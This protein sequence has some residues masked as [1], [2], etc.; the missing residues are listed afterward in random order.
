M[1]DPVQKD[2]NHVTL[3]SYIRLVS[4]TKLWLHCH[5]DLLHLK[6]PLPLTAT[7]KIFASEQFQIKSVPKSQ[8]E[9]QQYV[10]SRLHILHN[11]LN[12][13]SLRHFV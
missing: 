11:Y 10:Q 3:G 2:V 13:V 9:K 7:K 1:L 12:T 4:A 6:K 8:I 5:S